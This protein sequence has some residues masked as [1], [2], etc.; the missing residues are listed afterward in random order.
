MVRD[1]QPNLASTLRKRVSA[2]VSDER[3]LIAEAKLSQV[4]QNDVRE[5]PREC[6]PVCVPPCGKKLPGA[7]K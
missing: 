1:P 3:R 6:L 5:R 7:I 2:I 4:F